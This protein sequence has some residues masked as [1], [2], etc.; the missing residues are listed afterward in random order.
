MSTHVYSNGVMASRN[1]QEHDRL[2]TTYC[3]FSEARLNDYYT[4][5]LDASYC[6]D[7]PQMLP[8]GSWQGWHKFNVAI[9]SETVRGY[10]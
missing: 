5:E 7:A 10:E 2:C 1:R 6:L 3:A 4:A 8:A 9:E